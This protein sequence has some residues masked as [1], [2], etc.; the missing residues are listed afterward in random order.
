LSGDDRVGWGTDSPEQR[1]IV[2]DVEGTRLVVNSVL[3]SGDG[4]ELEAIIDSIDFD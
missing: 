1:V 4:Q 3:Y 2:L